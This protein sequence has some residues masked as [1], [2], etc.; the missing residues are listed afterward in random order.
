MKEH[1]PS[2]RLYAI[3][4]GPLPEGLGKP[5]YPF[6]AMQVGQWFDV[7]REL[8]H[9]VRVRASQQGQKYGRRYSVRRIEQDRTRVYRI[10]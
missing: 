7:P 8:D 5:K 9:A 4:S 2:N 3:Q 6:R 1:T 10:A